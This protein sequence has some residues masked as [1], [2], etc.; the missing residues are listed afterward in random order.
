M[1]HFKRTHSIIFLFTFFF[2]KH[3]A[4]MISVGHMTFNS[5]S[6]NIKGKC[7]KQ[8]KRDFYFFVSES[9]V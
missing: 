5:S 4:I 2:D 1:D 3:P 7:G 6:F 9:E 8:I